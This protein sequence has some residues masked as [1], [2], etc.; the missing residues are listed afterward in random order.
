ME[1][2]NEIDDRRNQRRLHRQRGGAIEGAVIG[3]Q[4]IFG[5]RNLR[6]DAPQLAPEVAAQRAVVILVAAP[7]CGAGKCHG[8]NAGGQNGRRKGTSLRAQ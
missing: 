7:E 5:E 3:R 4:Q 6:G 8:N 2:R 1:R